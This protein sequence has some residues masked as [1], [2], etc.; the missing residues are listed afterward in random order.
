[1]GVL[2]HLRTD[3][4]FHQTR[5]LRYICG[6]R[7]GFSYDSATDS[8]PVVL[9]PGLLEALFGN[10]LAESWP[11]GFYSSWPMFTLTLHMLVWL[12]AERVY[13]RGRF[14]NYAMLGDDLVIADQK[15]ATE[16]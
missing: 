5:P 3:G 8:L 10:H 15:V 16:Y 9:T 13:P 2:S 1:M 14:L 4:T 11:L 12:S 6:I 7:N